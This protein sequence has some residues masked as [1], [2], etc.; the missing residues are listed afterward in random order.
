MFPS[1]GAGVYC[2]TV[3]FDRAGLWRV[4]VRANVD[5]QKR[6]RIVRRAPSIGYRELPAS[7]L[8]ESIRVPTRQE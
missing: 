6:G 7:W 8:K 4:T 5:G 2:A 1:D 3:T